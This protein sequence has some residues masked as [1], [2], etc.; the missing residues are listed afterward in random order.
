MTI[1]ASNE[2]N[3]MP[4]AGSDQRMAIQIMPEADFSPNEDTYYMTSVC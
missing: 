4:Y 1:I 2:A 3:I